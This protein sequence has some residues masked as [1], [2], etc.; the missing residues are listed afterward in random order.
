[1]GGIGDPSANCSLIGRTRVM[2]IFNTGA[3]AHSHIN[4][5]AFVFFAK[6]IGGM[7]GREREREKG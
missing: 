1:M 7:E 3:E 6:K 2:K 5:L 4:S